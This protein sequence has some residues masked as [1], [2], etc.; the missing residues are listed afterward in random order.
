MLRGVFFFFLDW[1]TKEPRAGSKGQL[2]KYGRDSVH[3]ENFTPIHSILFRSVG[4]LVV[5]KAVIISFKSIFG[6]LNKVAKTQLD[7]VSLKT[8]LDQYLSRPS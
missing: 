5:L 8:L 3:F 1:P 6:S 4:V 2:L 7:Q